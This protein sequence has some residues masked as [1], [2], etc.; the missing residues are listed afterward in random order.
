MVFSTSLLM[1]HLK[2]AAGKLSLELWVTVIRQ[3]H[4]RSTQTTDDAN[5]HQHKTTPY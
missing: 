4:A 3:I 1:N 2:S 5:T